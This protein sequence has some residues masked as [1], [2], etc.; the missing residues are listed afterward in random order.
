M[1]M[2]NPIYEG[3]NGVNE[4]YEIEAD[5]TEMKL[6]DEYIAKTKTKIIY[7]NDKLSSS[8]FNDVVFSIKIEDNS[9][10]EAII[11]ELTE[12]KNFFPSISNHFYE[13]G[14][15]HL[16]TKSINN[17]IG[18][19]K[20]FIDHIDEVSEK[21]IQKVIAQLLEMLSQVHL[22]K[23]NFAQLALDDIFID[24]DND[25]IILLNILQLKKDEGNIDVKVIS[26]LIK[27]IIK[28]YMIY[29]DDK[30][31]NP[32][33]FRRNKS[34]NI[35]NNFSF[36][37]SNSLSEE[38]NE[39]FEILSKNDLTIEDIAE[40]QFMRNGKIT[41]QKTMKNKKVIGC[42]NDI[43]IGELVSKFKA[44][45]LAVIDEDN[46]D[47]TLLSKVI[48]DCS[49]KQKKKKLICL[50]DK[51]RKQVKK[52]KLYSSAIVGSS[53]MK[54]KSFEESQSII[55]TERKE[56]KTPIRITF[57]PLDM[58]LVNTGSM[59]MIEA[60]M[61]ERKKEI[62]RLR[63]PLVNENNNIWEKIKSIFN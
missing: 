15:I 63:V 49:K 41:K 52:A 29:S 37:Q 36:N 34:V 22:R 32:P 3:V 39:L 54:N 51:K 60:A 58:V 19:G 16:I 31:S 53:Q 7:I 57:K 43:N 55:V 13:N 11:E 9:Q 48:S 18:L 59:E 14:K 1:F 8:F 17:S 30:S 62:P 25:N 24:V 28:M 56:K 12:Q 26:K 23:M 44:S 4:Q 38:L 46:S 61:K 27:E 21:T 5:S 35:V 50:D 6:S 20:M 10:I 45:Q 47:E 33:S 40:S 2:M 42:N